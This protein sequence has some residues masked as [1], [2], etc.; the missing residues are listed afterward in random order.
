MY[1]CNKEVYGFLPVPLR[2]HSS[3]QDEAESFM[4]V[5]LEV[6]GKSPWP[7]PC[8]L[9]SLELI[10]YCCVVVP[11]WC[12]T[13]G[14]HSPCHWGVCSSRR[15]SCHPDR[16]CLLCA[17]AHTTHTLRKLT[18]ELLSVAHARELGSLEAETKRWR[19]AFIW[20]YSLTIHPK[21]LVLFC[22]TVFCS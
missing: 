14:D 21:R 20:G 22:N 5:Q 9:T 3:L 8:H 7:W 16:H 17:C 12:V 4:H 2:A 19:V 11:V 18:H 15:I 6:M 13:E 1:V 10:G